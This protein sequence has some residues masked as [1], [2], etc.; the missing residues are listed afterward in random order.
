MSRLTFNEEDV[1]K[2]L[3]P[4][5]S[6]PLWQEFNKPYMRNCLSLVKQE[7]QGFSVAPPKGHVYRAYQLCPLDQVKVVIVGQDPYPTEGHASG[8]AFG[9]HKD[10]VGSMPKS[11]INIIKELE[12]DLGFRGFVDPTLEH[13]A[14]QGVFLINTCLTVRIGQIY[15][16]AN[17][18]WG[19]FIMATFDVLSDTP[20]IVWLLWGS[21]A[22]KIASSYINPYNQMVIST[23]HPSPMSAHQSFFGSKCFS[24]INRCL[25]LMGREEINWY[26]SKKPPRHP[27]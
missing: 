7:R 15:S 22:Q 12:N 23:S 20:N 25:K 27:S 6:K 26:R 16:H 3:G 24:D 18:G 21:V 13:W 1:A 10:H 11:L 8:L 17:I 4:S 14:N 2:L 19:E 5:W 9:V